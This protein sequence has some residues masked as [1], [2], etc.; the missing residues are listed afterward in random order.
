ME[1][2]REEAM[3]KRM[4]C[5]LGEVDLQKEDRRPKEGGGRSG[6]CMA[7]EDHR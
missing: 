1:G 7:T 4:N 2:G 6:L 3:L 5:E